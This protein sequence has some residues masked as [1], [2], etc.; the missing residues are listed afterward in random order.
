M[1]TRREFSKCVLAGGTALASSGSPENLLGAATPP[2]PSPQA[3]SNQ[4]IDL[5]IQGGTVI[6]P[7]QQLHATRDVAVKNGKIFEVAGNIP[8]ARAR[9]VFLAKGKIVTPG[10]I[11]LHLHA[12][13]GVTSCVNVDHYCYPRGTTTVVD[14]GSTGHIMVGRFITDVLK[15]SQ[16]RVYTM[17]HIC[18]IGPVS[19]LPHALENLDWVN[20]VLTAEAAET[21]RPYVIAIKVHLSKGYSSSPQ[22]HEKPIMAGALKAAELSHLPLMVH[23]NDTYY[24]LREHLD[25]MRKG[26]IFTHCFNSFPTT[27]PLDANGKVLP[28]IRDARQRGVIFDIAPGFMHP[29]FTFDIA[30]KC[31]QQDFPPDTISTDLNKENAA[32][33]IYDMPTMVSKF[34]ALG[35]SLDKAIECATT[36]PAKIFN[37]GVQIGTLR[38]GSEGDIAIF[39]LDEGVF[40]FKDAVGGIRKGRQKLVSHAVVSR[41]RLFANE[42]GSDVIGARE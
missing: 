15:T 9:K 7:G 14:A 26:D 17:V 38:P 16:T 13:D 41:G 34:L 12:Y 19:G 5:L 3:D 22:S 24:P 1:L 11:D 31:I 40:E 4:D 27:T 37:Y 18:P 42:S 8:A 21:N 20:P 29:H 2:R 39:D 25:K 32:V 36:N 6:D 10:L 28:E 33:G 30:E 35:M 23:L